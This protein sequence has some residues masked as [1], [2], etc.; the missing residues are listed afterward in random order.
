MNSAK[1]AIKDFMSR[2]GHH[3]TTVHEKVAPAVVH[4]TVEPSEARGVQPV[5]D[6]EIIP[7]Q[8]LHNIIP[9]EHRSFEHNKAEK[10]KEK[11]AAEQAQFRD[12]KQ[13]VKGSTQ[14][15][16]APIVAG[17]HVHLKV[18][19]TIQPVI[20]KQTIEP[21]VVHTTVPLHEVHHNAAQ[22]HSAYALPAVS[23]TTFKNQGGVLTGREERYD[24]FE[25]K[26]RA[27]GGALGSTTGT[28]GTSGPTGLHGTHDSSLTGSHGTGSGLTGGHGITDLG[29]T[30][31][32]LTGG[33]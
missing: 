17:E 30:G 10:V 29:P 24:G 6:R 22:H 27:I 8:H 31:S 26:P 23:I 9:V 1:A 3:D 14:R 5:K 12:D 2:S 25:G 13:V 33:T 20:E 32:D 15:S 4:E 19:E 7:E 16:V 11:L 18:H 21:Q 28:S